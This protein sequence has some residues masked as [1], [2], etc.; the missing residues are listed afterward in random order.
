MA[1]F[2]A[3]WRIRFFGTNSNTKLFNGQ[4]RSIRPGRPT[5]RSSTMR[6]RLDHPVSGPLPDA[7]TRR[8]D[9]LLLSIPSRISGTWPSYGGNDQRFWEEF[10]DYVLGFRQN[11]AGVYQDVSGMAG[12]GSDFT[13][14][15][16]SISGVP[17]APSP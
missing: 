7:V 4:G 1:H 3:D 5:I 11:A 16:A 10:I 2:S 6:P 17:A 15:T 8:P 12:Y 9:D 14:G 13:W